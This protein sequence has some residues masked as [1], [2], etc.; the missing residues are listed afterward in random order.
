MRNRPLAHLKRTSPYPRVLPLS[1]VLRTGEEERIS[2]YTVRSVVARRMKRTYR[3][4]FVFLTGKPGS[5]RMHTASSA[6]GILNMEK[7]H[8]NIPLSGNHRTG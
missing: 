4:G 6:F 3:K 5:F 2:V 8:D 1:R 7:P